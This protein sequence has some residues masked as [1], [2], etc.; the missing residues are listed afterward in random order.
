MHASHRKL[1]SRLGAGFIVVGLIAFLA[2]TFFAFP[3]AAATEY[4]KHLGG[5]AV[6]LGVVPAELLRGKADDGTSMHAGLPSG[7]GSHHVLISIFDDRTGRQVEDAMVEARVGS[8]G[9]LSETTRV[10]EPMKIGPTTTYGNFFPMTAPGPFIVRVW[11]RRPGEP[12]PVEVQFN[13][14]HPK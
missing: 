9:H 5:L 6:Y 8:P 4:E 10:L 1:R 7:S 14:A 3:A 2:L 13:Y 12:L 11:I